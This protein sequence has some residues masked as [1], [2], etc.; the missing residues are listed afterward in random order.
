MTQR[1]SS[2]G[3]YEDLIGYS[4]AVLAGPFVLVSGCTST[5]DGAYEQTL[6]AFAVA[7]R[8]LNDAGLQRA[9]VVR[10]RMYL[11]DIALWEEVGR[12]HRELF[13]DVRPAA[14]MVA[15][16]ALIDPRML[17]EVEAVAHKPGSGW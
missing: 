2:G 7:E 10:T 12:A 16:S 3:P 14:T 9:D 11:T 6:A 4:R 17:V 13:A 1:M 15:V 5:A 8:A